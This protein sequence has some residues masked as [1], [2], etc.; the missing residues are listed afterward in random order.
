MHYTVSPLTNNSFLSVI[1]LSLTHVMNSPIVP[2][3]EQ[4]PFVNTSRALY[5]VITHIVCEK[6][7]TATNKIRYAHWLL[8]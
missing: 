1:M 5:I 8:T 6:L 4:K 2:E 7:C 3:C